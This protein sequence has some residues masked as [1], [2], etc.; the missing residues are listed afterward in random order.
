MFYKS[1]FEKRDART[2]F[3]ALQK[4]YHKMQEIASAN[5][6]QHENTIHC[7]P[8]RIRGLLLLDDKTRSWLRNI[9]ASFRTRLRNYLGQ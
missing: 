7:A 9:T 2:N 1:M 6:L 8:K 5:M 3:A 4:N